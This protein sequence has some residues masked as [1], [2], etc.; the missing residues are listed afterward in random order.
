[1]AMPEDAEPVQRSY[2]VSVLSVG[3]HVISLQRLSRHGRIGAEISDIQA[4]LA[5]GDLAKLRVV[6][7]MLWTRRLLQFQTRG[8]VPGDGCEQDQRFSPL[9]RPLIGSTNTSKATGHELRR[10]KCVWCSHITIHADDGDRFRDQH[11]LALDRCRARLG[12]R[13]LALCPLRVFGF[14]PHFNGHCAD[15][16]KPSDLQLGRPRM[17][18]TAS[19][20]SGAPPQVKAGA[21][22]AASEFS[23]QPPS[24]RAPPVPSKDRRSIRCRLRLL[25]MLVTLAIAAA[26]AGAAWLMWQNYMGKPWT[27]DGT[28]RA[29]VVTLAPDIAGQVVQLP[30]KDNQFVHKGDLLIKIDPRDYQVA[31][32]LS[33]AAVDQADADYENKKVQAARRVALS[34]LSTSREERQTF[35]AAAAMAAAT[36]S[37]KRPTS[38]EQIS[39]SNGQ[40]C[41]RR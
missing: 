10:A 29:N 24:A 7:S 1:M 39:I 4:N 9:A 35:G 3:L 22:P 18:E 26:G 6:L 12:A 31:V 30:V 21:E 19:S 5:A 33:K 37:S 23:S 16:R 34:D 14:H 38:S 41:A 20:P 17:S 40:K 13:Y 28:V 32:D 11:G 2:L 8:R 36:L 15:V 25:P 27:R